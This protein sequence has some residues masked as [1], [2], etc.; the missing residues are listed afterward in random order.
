[1]RKCAKCGSEEHVKVTT[2]RDEVEWLC[3]DCIEE[4]EKIY[5]D[6]LIAEGVL[7]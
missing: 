3:A 6:E 2:I 7:L 1:M 4:V 5:M